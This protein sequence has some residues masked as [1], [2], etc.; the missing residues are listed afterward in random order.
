MKVNYL[1]KSFTVRRI[2]NQR[3]AKNKID[4][5]QFYSN[6]VTIKSQIENGIEM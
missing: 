2:K 6:I 3:L 5:S 4:I 1:N